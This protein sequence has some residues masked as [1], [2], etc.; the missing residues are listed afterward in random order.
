MYSHINMTE[1]KEQIDLDQLNGT[2][3]EQLLALLLLL[4]VYSW[5]THRGE[6]WSP[7]NNDTVSRQNAILRDGL[8]KNHLQVMSES[9]IIAMFEIQELFLSKLERIINDI[10]TFSYNN[11]V[12]LRQE[13]KQELRKD[14]ANIRDENARLATNLADV[15][16][17][18]NINRKLVVLGSVVLATVLVSTLLTFTA[19]AMLSGGLSM[20]ASPLV[21]LG[22]LACAAMYF[23]FV[24]VE[25]ATRL[26]SGYKI[27]KHFSKNMARHSLKQNS[28]A[29]PSSAN[30]RSGVST[31]HQGSSVEQPAATTKDIIKLG[32]FRTAT[33]GTH[34]SYDV[35]KHH[36]TGRAHWL[37]DHVDKENASI[38]GWRRRAA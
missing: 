33:L 13:D 26:Y 25:I 3:E 6:E 7:K 4:E 14:I 8:W 24:G 35:V 18:A 32:L 29:K 27:N 22:V 37:S 34:D 11:D 31:P 23:S 10:P 15:E 20:V 21:M 12:F 36:K 19:I 5:N 28:E 30:A 17:I 38:A 2:L 16:R 1:V 9:E